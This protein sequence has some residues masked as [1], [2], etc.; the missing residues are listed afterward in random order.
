MDFFDKVSGTHVGNTIL[1]DHNQVR[2][3]RIPIE[4]VILIEKWNG[5]VDVSVKYLMKE[6]LPYL[7]VLHSTCNFVFTFV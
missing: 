5:R 4:N 2:T 6:V 7:E 3:M 1:I